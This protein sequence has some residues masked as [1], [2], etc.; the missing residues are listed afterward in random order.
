[1][2]RGVAQQGGFS[3]QEFLFLLAFLLLLASLALPA[4]EFVKRW[5]R[6]V[7]ARGD[8]RSVVAAVHRFHS[9]YN[10]WPGS[11]PVHAGD[12]HFGRRISNSH[13]MN[14]LRSVEG[15]G[16]QDHAMNSNR[17]VFLDVASASAGLSGLD[18]NGD[19]VDPWGSQYRIVLDLDY[20]GVCEVSDS[21]YGRV[22]GEGVIVWSCGPDGK[23]DTEDD[24]QSWKWSASRRVFGS[25]L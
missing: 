5:Q 6:L 25:S 21:I 19:F 16:N 13:V 9:Q 4:R 1:M 23:S 2:L 22:Q 15:A 11:A 7:M 12:I 14:I 8:L 24:L 10:V 18:A 17:V 20:D 3:R